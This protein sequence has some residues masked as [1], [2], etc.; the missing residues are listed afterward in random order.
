MFDLTDIETDTILRKGLEYADALARLAGSFKSEYLQISHQVEA[1]LENLEHTHGRDLGFWAKRERQQILN[2]LKPGPEAMWEAFFAARVKEQEFYY[3]HDLFRPKVD[4]DTYLTETLKELMN[5][6][7]LSDA[8]AVATGRQI[9][10]QVSRESKLLRSMGYDEAFEI[11]F[12]V[13]SSAL[14]D[15]QR[16]YRS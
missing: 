5:L 6:D 13:H 8:T 2:Q 3:S 15:A 11:E 12:G 14:M 7:R 9:L 1:D 4:A 10:E 16:G